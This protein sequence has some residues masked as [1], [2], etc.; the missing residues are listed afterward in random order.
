MMM[1]MMTMMM[2]MMMMMMMQ[3]DLASQGQ[4]YWTMLWATRTSGR[5]DVMLGMPVSCYPEAG[6]LV[7][8]GTL[9]LRI[10]KDGF[11]V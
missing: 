7:R 6:S 1:M 11:R 8:L 9:K 5:T 4:G 10:P 3:H 2:M